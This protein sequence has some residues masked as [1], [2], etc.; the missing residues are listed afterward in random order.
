MNDWSARDIQKWEYIPLGPFNAKNFCTTISPWIIT[1]DALKVLR[2]DLPKQEP[3][4]LPYLCDKNDYLFDVNLDVYI[5]TN[6]MKNKQLICQS[7]TKYLYYSCHQQLSHHTITGCPFNA[8][9]LLGSGTISGT[10]KNQFGSLLELSWSGKEPFQLND[11]STRS[12]LEDGDKITITGSQKAKNGDFIIG[13]GECNGVILPAHD[14]T[15]LGK[16]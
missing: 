8:G 4:L 9:D 15:M 1:M 16:L 3:E 7:N 14:P 11:G 10:Q 13:F 2:M 6:K 12:F 5:Q